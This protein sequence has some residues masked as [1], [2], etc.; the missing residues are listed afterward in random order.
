MS[1]KALT[2]PSAQPSEIFF[3]NEFA[4]QA[5]ENKIS[6]GKSVRLVGRLE[7]VNVKRERACLC[8]QGQS[9][10]VDTS[11]LEA[12]LP[13]PVGNYLQI[14][15]E[16]TGRVERSNRFGALHLVKARVAISSGNLDVALFG[17]ALSLRRQ[18]LERRE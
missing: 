16:Y 5:K 12:P 15:G 6:V 1:S 9:L 4:T 13:V 3:V 7:Y 11:N 14:F 2:L 10:G 17:E 8:H 18:F